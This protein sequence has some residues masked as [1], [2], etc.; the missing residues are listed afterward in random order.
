MKRKALTAEQQRVR[1]AEL[2]VMKDVRI[3]KQVNASIPATFKK[4][5]HKKMRCED[6][7]STVK[8]RITEATVVFWPIR[9]WIQ[10]CRTCEYF[11]NPKTR[12]YEFSWQQAHSASL[13]ATGYHRK[14]NKLL[15]TT[16]EAKRNLQLYRNQMQS[17]RLHKQMT[18]RQRSKNHKLLDKENSE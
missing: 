16:D 3:N 12:R 17:I 11:F 10:K 6:C 4:I 1:I 2:A 7:S 5:R 8:N 18:N 9:H 13:T 15:E 14:K